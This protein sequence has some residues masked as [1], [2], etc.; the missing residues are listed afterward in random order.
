MAIESYWH[1]SFGKVAY[2]QRSADDVMLLLLSWPITASGLCHH[3][4]FEIAKYC[5]GLG[6]LQLCWYDRFTGLESL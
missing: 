1:S 2:S 4:L 6:I 5:N 3:I